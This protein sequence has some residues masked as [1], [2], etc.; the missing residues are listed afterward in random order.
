MAFS[1]DFRPN[2]FR[3]NLKWQ[4]NSYSVAALRENGL[5]PVANPSITSISSNE[6]IWGK[7]ESMAVGAQGERQ[8]YK[9]VNKRRKAVLCVSSGEQNRTMQILYLQITCARNPNN[10]GG[11]YVWQQN[12]SDNSMALVV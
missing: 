5:H 3:P 2:C 8:R 6:I 1:T 4:A 7:T 10:D 12:E 11:I 9:R